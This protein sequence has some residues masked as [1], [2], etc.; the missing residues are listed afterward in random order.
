MTDLTSIR[1]P[2]TFVYLAGLLDAWSRRC[3]GWH[4]ARSLDTSLA[5][6]ALEQALTARQPAPGLLHH[7][8][9]GVQYAST[10]YVARLTAAGARISRSAKGSPYDNANAES[11]FKTRKTE[12]VYLNDDQ[13][14]ADA[15]AHLDRFIADVYNAKR[16]HSSLGYS[17]PN[18]FEAHYQATPAPPR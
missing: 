15:E 18:E 16:L 12:E 5:L 11:F 4:L 17:A 3:L 9:R 13:T 8:D 14:F 2:T 1:L 10:A 6:A 7:S